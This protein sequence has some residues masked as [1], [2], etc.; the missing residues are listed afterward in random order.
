MSHNLAFV[1][2]RARQVRVVKLVLVLVVPTQIR[3][4]TYETRVLQRV[5]I[6]VAPR[7][8]VYQVLVG[9]Y[10]HSFYIGRSHTYISTLCTNSKY[11]LHKSSFITT[12]YFINSSFANSRFLQL[13]SCIIPS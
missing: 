10:L 12:Q 5:Q 2:G 8:V 7:E 9:P 11:L 6:R 1:L 4:P 13:I 3:H